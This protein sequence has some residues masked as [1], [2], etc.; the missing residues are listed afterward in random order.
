MAEVHKVKNK[1]KEAAR[2]AKEAE[3]AAAR[4]KRDDDED[5]DGGGGGANGVELRNGLLVTV[6]EAEDADDDTLVMLSKG[7]AY[8]TAEWAETLLKPDFHWDF[9][10]L[11]R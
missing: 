4:R 9:G 7:I 6:E 8:A 1:R 10:R 11:L 2:V 5:R 3:K